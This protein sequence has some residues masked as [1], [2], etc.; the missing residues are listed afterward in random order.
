MPPRGCSSMVEPQS[1]KLITRVRFPSSPPSKYRAERPMDGLSMSVHHRQEYRIDAQREAIHAE[2]ECRGWE[3]EGFEDAGKSSH[4][5]PDRYSLIPYTAAMSEPDSSQSASPTAPAGWYPDPSNGQ[6]RYWDG[7]AWTNIT[8][9]PPVAGAAP[10]T[11]VQVAHRPI[12]V[13]AV[14]G[15]VL[16]ILAF[17][18]VGFNL[19]P[20]T[21]PGCAS[22]FDLSGAPRFGRG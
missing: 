4:N 5:T 8:P 11:L 17:L 21:R 2:T 9:P 14:V 20:P 7:N 6:Q 16:S 3:F 12:S 19:N 13:P 1:S 22:D 18:G 15:F 10:V